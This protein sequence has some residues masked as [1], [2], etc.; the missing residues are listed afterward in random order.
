MCDRAGRDNIR[1][2]APEFQ[3]LDLATTL[4]PDRAQ[5]CQPDS[6]RAQRHAEQT[7]ARLTT[8]TPHRDSGAPG[9]TPA[10]TSRGPT[11]P[12]APPP[13]CRGRF[14]TRSAPP[15]DGF[16]AVSCAPSSMCVASTAIGR[17]AGKVAA[18][19]N[20]VGDPAG[21]V[22]GGAVS[23]ERWSCQGWR[24]A[25]V[26]HVRVG[27]LALSQGVSETWVPG[28]PIR[29][30]SM[31]RACRGGMCYARQTTYT[32]PAR[33]SPERGPR[34]ETSRSFTGLRSGSRRGASRGPLERCLKSY[35]RDRCRSSEVR[36][37]SSDGTGDERGFR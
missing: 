5:R 2:R 18:L 27:A 9:S 23:A 15:V 29:G 4:V 7:P 33:W 11:R 10:S 16:E 3:L 20:P 24:D 37:S 6:V 17:N 36:R 12:A 14:S 35:P 21:G 8:I 26:N 13:G 32:S 22:C 1:L 19:I 25:G 30:L 31:S 34:F 28:G